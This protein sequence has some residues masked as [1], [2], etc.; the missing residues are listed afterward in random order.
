[1]HGIEQRSELDSLSAKIRLLS[2]PATFS[3][4]PVSIQ[5]V[6]THLSC[7]FLAG[8]F[9]FKLKRPVR[10]D[11]ADFHTPDQRLQACRDEIRL[12][13]RLAPDVYL[14][15][16]PIT[17]SHG[18]A[19][20]AGDGETT[21]WV[22]RMQRLPSDRSLDQMIQNKTISSKA[23]ETLVETL[24][25]FYLGLPP[26]T[27]CVDRFCLR[28]EDAIRENL[29]TLSELG[30]SASHRLV[31]QIGLSQL[32]VLDRHSDA[33]GERVVDGR[34]VEGHGDLR[35]EHVFF[36]PG[37]KIIDCI[38]FKLA[39][40]Q[41]DALDDLSFLAMECDYLGAPEIG[42][43]VVDRCCETNDDH[44]SPVLIAFYK[45]HRAVIRAKTLIL[46]AA[47]ASVRSRPAPNAAVRYLE[48]AQSYLETIPLSPIRH[49]HHR[50]SLP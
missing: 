23:I 7:V 30:P 9:A 2:D 22:L 47:I 4:R 24:T 29:S 13:R 1:M 27:I 43:R 33:I 44:P 37:T 45:S 40:R 25:E 16:L 17:V 20:L 28:L 3:H 48:L 15:I 6:E 19:A 35:P 50:E 41:L 36:D 11:F 18:R 39:W 14:N 31:R 26:I 21:D 8:Q 49:R 42:R 5:V 46:Q 32:R 10:F 34:I 12:N 38:E